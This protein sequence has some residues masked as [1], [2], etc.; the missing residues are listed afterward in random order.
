VRETRARSRNRDGKSERDVNVHCF[1]QVDSKTYLDRRCVVHWKRQTSSGELTVYIDIGNQ[2]YSKTSGGYF[3][4]IQKPG[5]TTSSWSADWNAGESHAHNYLGELKRV[6]DC[7]V[8]NRAKICAGRTKTTFR[9]APQSFHAPLPPTREPQG[10]APQTF[11]APKIEA[12]LPPAREPQRSMGWSKG[13]RWSDPR[14]NVDDWEAAQAPNLSTNV[15]STPAP[16]EPMKSITARHFLESWPSLI[17]QNVM[18]EYCTIT[19]VGASEIMCAVFDGARVL[20]YIRLSVIG[21]SARAVAWSRDTCHQKR[22]SVACSISVT[23]TVR[24]VGGRPGLSF[25][26]FEPSA[27][28]V[29]RA[30]STPA[31]KRE[32]PQVDSVT[33]LT[34]L[35]SGLRSLAGC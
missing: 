5:R 12:V 20:D 35:P 10:D 2:E 8:N 4:Y 23:G 34:R 29:Q 6:G 28:P 18:T 22:P 32:Q 26:N 21:L 13:S 33:S 30:A 31:P 1:I 9:D 25:A 7:W 3:V 15:A 17:G 19:H 16:V 24:D 11:H 14:A 27:I